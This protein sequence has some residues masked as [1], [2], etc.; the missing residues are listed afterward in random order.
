M[1]RGLAT[2]PLSGGTSRGPVVGPGGSPLG[3]AAG[4]VGSGAPGPTATKIKYENPQPIT[5]EYFEYSN[6]AYK[7][8]TENNNYNLIDHQRDKYACP[9]ATAFNT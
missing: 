4:S 5:P 1:A 7:R 6:E 3:E 9:I 8:R 2:G